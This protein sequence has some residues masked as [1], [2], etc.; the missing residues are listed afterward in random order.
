MSGCTP[1]IILLL[2]DIIIYLYS[3]CQILCK[4]FL[5][6]STKTIVSLSPKL[7][8]SNIRTYFLI[9]KGIPHKSFQ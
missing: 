4:F 9:F 6:L 1:D 8:I 7:N 3:Y 5:T 2:N